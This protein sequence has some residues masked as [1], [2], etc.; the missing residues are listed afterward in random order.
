MSAEQEIRNARIT[1]VMLGFEDHGILTAFVHVA[2]SG[3]GQG[4]GGYDLRCG[5]SAAEFIEGCLRA[6][7]RE[8]WEDLPGEPCRVIRQGGLLV[9][10]GHF[11]EDSW[12]KRGGQA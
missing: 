12:Y 7:K 11:V 5:R 9:A 4:F 6:L 3:W 10:I 1:N 8:R 2:G